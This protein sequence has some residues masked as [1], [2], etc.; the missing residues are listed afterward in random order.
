MVR[1]GRLAKAESRG[2]VANADL[3]VNANERRED[4]QPR[5]I[6]KCFE[7]VRFGGE[8]AS[9]R[10]ALPEPAAFASTYVDPDGLPRPTVNARALPAAPWRRSSAP[11]AG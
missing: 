10:P 5:R 6:G 8:I 11:T 9:I 7:K 2:E 1:N 4:R 3:V